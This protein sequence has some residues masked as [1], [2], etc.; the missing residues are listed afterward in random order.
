MR[1]EWKMFWSHNIFLDRVRMRRGRYLSAKKDEMNEWESEEI[2]ERKESER[3]KGR[4][5]RSVIDNETSS[6]FL[7]LSYLFSTVLSLSID[8]VFSSFRLFLFLSSTSVIEW[9][10]NSSDSV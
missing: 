5:S 9:V 10:T 3:E 7:S 2:R 8:D 1:K 6:S 4:K